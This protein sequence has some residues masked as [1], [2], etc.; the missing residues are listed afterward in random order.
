MTPDANAFAEAEAALNIGDRL[1][2]RT[3][4][5]TPSNEVA[6]LAGVPWLEA[7]KHHAYVAALVFDLHRQIGDVA[8]LG[9]PLDAEQRAIGVVAYV[10]GFGVGAERIALHD[11]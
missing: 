6:R 7:D 11:P 5:W 10:R 3:R 9:H 2:V 8:G 1:V 4:N